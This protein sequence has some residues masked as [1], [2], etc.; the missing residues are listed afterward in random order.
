MWKKPFETLI[1]VILGKIDRNLLFVVEVWVS[2]VFLF[3]LV[4]CDC[5]DCVSSPSSIKNI[6]KTNTLKQ[7]NN[8][9]INNNH[10]TVQLSV[11]YHCTHFPPATVLRDGYSV[12]LLIA[13]LKF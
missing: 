11:S 4:A 9:P 6:I 2:F 13:F 3:F 1:L 7:T 5:S 12:H 8:N 10:I